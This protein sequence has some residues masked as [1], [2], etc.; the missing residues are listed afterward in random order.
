MDNNDFILKIVAEL[1]K[2]GI[3]T[4]YDKL[5]K[6]LEKDPAKIDVILDTSGT[7]GRTKGSV[8]KLAFELHNELVKELNKMKKA[9]QYVNI[10]LSVGDVEKVINNIITQTDKLEKEFD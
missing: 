4:G 8:K 6:E 7:L 3:K 1:E 9:G 10:D 5:K 2:N